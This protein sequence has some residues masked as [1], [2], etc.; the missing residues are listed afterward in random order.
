MYERESAI[1]AFFRF[2]LAHAVEQLAQLYQAW[3]KPEQAAEWRAK[4]KP[5]EGAKE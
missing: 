4:L 1:P 5:G 3:G 2:N